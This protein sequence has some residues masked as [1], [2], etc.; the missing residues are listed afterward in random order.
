MQLCIKANDLEFIDKKFSLKSL[1]QSLK[2]LTLKY[3][4]SPIFEILFQP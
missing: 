1:I 2:S 3:V 4:S